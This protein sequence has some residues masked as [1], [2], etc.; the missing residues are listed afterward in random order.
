MFPLIVLAFV[1]S[2]L[3]QTALPTEG[4]IQAALTRGEALYFEARFADSISLL[5]P[6]DTALQAQ[7]DRIPERVSVKLFLALAHVG[8]NEPDAAKSLF[9]DITRLD[10]AFSLDAE[11][12]PPKII[13]LFGE[14]KAET[15]N[16]TCIRIC[17][18]VD[19]E[20]RAGN[21]EVAV[22]QAQSAVHC[23]CYNRAL[24]DLVETFHRLGMDS[25]KQNNLQDAMKQFRTALS[26]AP[27]HDLAAQYVQLIQ[28]KI[29]IATE[30]RLLDWRTSFTAGD[31][32][33]ASAGYRDLLSLTDEGGA[34]LLDQARNVYRQALD[35]L[36]ESWRKACAN[37]DDIEMQKVRQRAI[38]MI[39]EESM[40]RDFL[41]QTS[42]CPTQKSCIPVDSAVMLSNV[43]SFIPISSPVLAPFQGRHIHALI[44]VDEYGNT[45]VEQLSGGNS[46]IDV[47]VK[48][49]LEQWK[50]VPTIVEGE[51]RCV[52]TDIRMQL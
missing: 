24:L 22:T 31:F 51:P 14:T 10:P 52:S 16:N 5:Q 15:T 44:K 12:F 46:A 40:G 33:K 18:A 30:Q 47:F 28:D 1:V 34:T 17:D 8:L 6:F 13:K 49:T 41:A 3:Q 32:R 2:F 23:S 36:I 29:H 27:E 37:Q 42:S 7:T 20:R 11:R 19:R 4:D 43:R 26:L 9:A 45:T 35:S 39:P 21:P 38:D 48:S 25:Y 50:F